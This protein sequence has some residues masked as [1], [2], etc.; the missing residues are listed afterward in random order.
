MDI[1]QKFG[2]EFLAWFRAHTEAAWARY[3]TTDFTTP[4]SAGVDWMN[5]THWLPG[6]STE[7]IDAIEQKWS[8]RFPP[9]YRLFLQLLHAVDRPMIAASFREQG[10][11]L[12]ESPAFY[13]WLTDTA[14]IERRFTEPVEGLLF[15]VRYNDLWLPQWGN[16]PHALTVR[17]PRVRELAKSAPK[18]I[19]VFGHR[20]LVSEPY[21]A[22]NPV[23]SVSQADIVVYG[24]DLRAYLLRELADVLNLRTL[25]WLGNM[26]PSTS[27]VNIPFWGDFIQ[28]RQSK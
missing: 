20:F 23:I 19:P 21:Q 1:P 18:L 16:M 5:G 24:S 2:T 22:G 27:I 9:D 25:D 14:E 13:N 8:V 28:K 26:T 12:G 10:I 7:A 17:E 15:D 4:P 3:Q 6:L 11:I